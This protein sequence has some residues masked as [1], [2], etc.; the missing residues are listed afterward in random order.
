MPRE[1][2]RRIWDVFV[3]E[4]SWK[5]LFR[6]ALA[7]LAL[8][9]PELLVRDL[10]EMMSFLQRYPKARAA[11]R[12]DASRRDTIRR[13]PQ[14]AGSGAVPPK[15]WFGRAARGRAIATS[16]ASCDGKSRRSHAAHADA[17]SRTSPHD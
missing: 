1:T 8:A 10:A 15:T 17:R 6:V 16:L 7:L 3:F 11:S 12:A 14:R 2:L 5:I 9:E 13:S 4:R